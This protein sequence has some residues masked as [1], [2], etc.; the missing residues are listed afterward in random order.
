LPAFG[1]E[2]LSGDTE[3]PGKEGDF[4]VL[5]D[6][7]EGGSVWAL[8]LPDAESSVDRFAFVPASEQFNSASFVIAGPQ[9]GGQEGSR[10]RPGPPD[11]TVALPE[12]F[13]AIA[14]FGSNPDGL[15]WRV[16]CEKDGAVMALVPEGVFV[17]GKNDRSAN[18]GPEHGVA[19]DSFYIDVYEV[20][21]EKYAAY[22][23]AVRSLKR[24]ITEPA[25]KPENRSEPVTGLSWAEVR[26]YALWTGRE[27]PTEAE[28][29]KAARGTQGFDFPWGNGP[30][31][32][33]RPRSPNQI[34]EVG[35]FQGD[36]SPLGVYDLAG[37]AREWCSD[38]YHEQ[39]YAQLARESGATSH[40]PAGPKSASG[41]SQRVVKGGDPQWFVWARSGGNMSDRLPDV[42][43][44]CAWRLKTARNPKR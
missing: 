14:E 26:A 4:L 2:R 24:P 15:P 36:V 20:T 18:A 34:D 9:A 8:D 17:Q 23:E 16:R 39:Y 5:E 22:R 43:F 32:W 30:A 1:A 37:N 41:A 28:W 42:G 19:L 38:F 31:V 3:L 40:N 10:G 27:L 13:S 35:S 44:R 21:Y 11:K 7:K 33:H 25:R 29:E 12:G 6:P